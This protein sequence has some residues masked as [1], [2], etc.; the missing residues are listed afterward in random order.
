MTDFLHASS[1]QGKLL[2]NLVNCYGWD[3]VATV[4]A[5][6]AYGSSIVE[7][8][9]NQAV[10]HSIQFLSTATFPIASNAPSNDEYLDLIRAAVRKT[11]ASGARIILLACFS[12]A[13]ADYFTIAMEEGLFGGP[14]TYLVS[15]AIFPVG[16]YDNLDDG[17]DK[18]V[19]DRFREHMR[20]MIG[21]SVEGVQPGILADEW[22]TAWMSAD[23]NEY[24][25]GGDES[26]PLV[27]SFALCRDSVYAL[28]WAIDR[29]I[30]RGEDPSDGNLLLASIQDETDFYG[31]TGKIILASN[32]D[33]ESK[34]D[35]WNLQDFS[36]DLTVVGKGDDRSLEFTK[37]TVFYDGTTN[38]PD[39][40]ERVF[41]DWGDA[42]AIV[43]LT[44]CSIGLVVT[45]I[46]LVVM[47]ANR[48]TPI[49]RYCSP[50]FVF[51]M[52]IGVLVG[53]ANVFAWTGE[54][55]SGICQLRPWLLMFNFVL[56]FGHLYAKAFRFLLVMRQRKKL[57]FRPIPDI[58][59]FLC[60]FFY[61]L[62]F[63]IPCIVWSAAYP[64]EVTRSD[65]SDN[66]KVNIICD[67]ENAAAIWGS[68]LGLGGLS[69]LV[70]VVV[71]FLNR[72]YHDFFSEATY[73]GYTM[74]TVC[75][76]CCIVQPLLFILAES[77]HAF[78][79][80]LMLGIFLG[81]AAVVVFMFF[82][83]IY[84]ILTPAKNTVPLDEA[85]SLKTKKNNS[86]PVI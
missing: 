86:S 62:L 30:R 72:N 50:R 65:N 42:E 76:T 3:R 75:I 51:G 29:L 18:D 36:F 33:R 7:E 64:L 70:G 22:V 53:F 38:V 25:G 61:L 66:D 71:A 81:N 34:Y 28:A 40:A 5:T 60:V 56:I 31:L 48:K 14:Y 10:L 21:V 15:D 44:L 6:D 73:I 17:T 9:M 43:M 16:I 45:S 39:A 59:L 8:F 12:D 57:L 63:A 35:I 24:F 19:V 4:C 23:P 82:P 85:G 20:G 80:V 41:V 37:E 46:C 77:P 58:Q 32:G 69:L 2:A 84:V 52:G 49:M 68:I 26:Y 27:P 79:L 11:K 1:P 55:T 54:P 74:F 78:Y 83:K 13:A 47:M 67:G